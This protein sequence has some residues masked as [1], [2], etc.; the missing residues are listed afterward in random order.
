MTTTSKILKRIYSNEAREISCLCT[1]YNNKPLSSI[2]KFHQAKTRHLQNI[3]RISIAINYDNKK[4]ITDKKLFDFFW[5]IVKFECA[6]TAFD[7]TF[8]LIVLF[9][10][11]TYESNEIF[12][13][14]KTNNNY[15]LMRLWNYHTIFQAIRWFPVISTMLCQQ[16]DKRK[17]FG[18][19][20]DWF[21][22]NF[23]N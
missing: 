5:Q 9:L 12:E 19:L 17:C 8:I 3:L 14:W 10:Y 2:F 15:N 23:T 18:M 21:H 13:K 22:L 20:V 1:S 16:W 11:I 4:Y 6:Y 7:C